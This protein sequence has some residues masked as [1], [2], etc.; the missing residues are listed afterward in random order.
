MRLNGGLTLQR[1]GFVEH[2]MR[3]ASATEAA[4]R[5]GYKNPSVM[6]NRLISSD[7][8]VRAMI[9]ERQ[10]EMAAQYKLTTERII[11]ELCCLA[12][13]NKAD[14][15]YV[16]PNGR[17]VFDLSRA[18]RDQMAAV[19]AIV[20]EDRTITRPSPFKLPNGKPYP[21]EVEH[22]QEMKLKLR[23]DKLQA[24]TLLGKHMGL[25]GEDD[26]NRSPGEF[27][28][29]LKMGNARIEARLSDGRQSELGQGAGSPTTSQ[30]VRLPASLDVS[31]AGSGDLLPAGRP[32]E[33]S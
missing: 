26:G 14:Y 6:G 28:F 33:P 11:H 31:G 17:F 2:Y 8:V 7:K 12:F 3:C 10:E 13:A 1:Q 16:G 5:A 18:T 25:F 4:R 20:I 24:L 19:E 21:P 23:G 9:D 32:G 22:I 27:E 15:G 30:E 29:T